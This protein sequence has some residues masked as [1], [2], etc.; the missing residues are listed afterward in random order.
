MPRKLADI[1]L[2]Q[3][4]G[5]ANVYRAIFFPMFLLFVDL[6]IR[7]GMIFK[8]RPAESYNRLL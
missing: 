1:Q 6:L 4:K 7:F 5:R 8:C 2:P 3:G